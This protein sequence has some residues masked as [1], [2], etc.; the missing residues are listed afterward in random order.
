M[1][2]R[3]PARH[4]SM[5]NASTSRDPRR[6]QERQRTREGRRRHEA[7]LAPDVHLASHPARPQRHDFK[8]EGS[9][10]GILKIRPRRH[11]CETSTRESDT[12]RAR[13]WPAVSS[14][15]PRVIA[16][17]RSWPSWSIPGS[18]TSPGSCQ[19]QE[20]FLQI[21]RR[22]VAVLWNMVTPDAHYKRC[23]LSIGQDQLM[24]VPR[25]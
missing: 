9:R 4:R 3:R 24:G 21:G 11:F 20:V 7:E 1:A 8:G 12:W 16:W 14:A 18:D 22:R 13:I 2:R 19:R 25:F 5:T 17:V 15:M 6:R 23:S 10:H